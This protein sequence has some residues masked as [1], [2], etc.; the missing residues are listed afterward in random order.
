MTIQCKY[1]QPM[2]VINGNEALSSASQRNK[3]IQISQSLMKHCSD[4]LDV[5]ALRQ[6]FQFGI[7][8]T[9][10]SAD[11]EAY[12]SLNS[13]KCG[14]PV[15]R[16]EKYYSLLIYWWSYWYNQ[17]NSVIST[18]SCLMRGEMRLAQI[19]HGIW[20]K[21]KQAACILFWLGW[22]W[23]V[24]EMS[25]LM[26]QYVCINAS[27]LIILHTRLAGWLWPLQL[28]LKSLVKCSIVLGWLMPISTL[29]RA[30]RKMKP[31]HFSLQPKCYDPDLFSVDDLQ[32]SVAV[33]IIILIFSV[34]LLFWLRRRWPLMAINE[35]WWWQKLTTHCNHYY[36]HCLLTTWSD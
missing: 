2:K 33:F 27:I 29:F 31:L 4:H 36:S 1:H 7:V 35:G 28:R 18:M 16:E 24:S 15:T 22:L 8:M 10:P 14:N 19:Q 12:Y 34:C 11:I 17:W 13:W 20:L 3:Y 32:Y 25:V 6:T 30:Q 9:I 21:Q 26:C 5:E 23:H